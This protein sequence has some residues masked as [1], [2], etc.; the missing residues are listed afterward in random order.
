MDPQPR[1]RSGQE[2]P[3][4]DRRGV[5]RNARPAGQRVKPDHDQHQRV[6][7]QILNRD[8]IAGADRAMTLVLQQRIQRY[9]EKPAAGT[10]DVAEAVAVPWPTGVAAS[11]AAHSFN[12]T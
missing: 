7:R 2:E 10:T 9:D 5:H 4:G 3:K 1:N 12:R 6:L 11:C 8:R